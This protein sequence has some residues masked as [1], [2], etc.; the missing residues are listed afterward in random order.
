VS[1]GKSAPFQFDGIQRYPCY[2]NP[3][4]Q[5]VEVVAES[6]P[7]AV[8]PNAFEQFGQV[9]GLIGGTYEKVFALQAQS[10]AAEAERQRQHH[11]QMIEL[12]RG[13]GQDK[14]ERALLLV[15]TE[16]RGMKERLDDLEEDKGE[17]GP[18]STVVEAGGVKLAVSEKLAKSLAT[19]LDKFG[20]RTIQGVVDKYLGGG[21]G[22][23]P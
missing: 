2:P 11:Q 5:R 17:A 20:E 3:P 18:G 12:T 13:A 7:V 19:L 21:P 15:T 14:L 22:G 8:R 4:K 6:A 23:D 16:L 9:Y 10:F 1:F